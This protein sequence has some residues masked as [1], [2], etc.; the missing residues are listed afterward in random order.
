MKQRYLPIAALI[1][2]HLRLRAAPLSY[3]SIAIH[4]RWPHSGLRSRPMA[5]T[6]SEQFSFAVGWA[7]PSRHSPG[8]SPATFHIN[9]P[10]SQDADSLTTQMLGY[11]Q[12][13]SPASLLPNGAPASSMV[14]SPLQKNHWTATW[15]QSKTHTQNILSPYLGVSLQFDL[16]WN[17]KSLSRQSQYLVSNIYNPNSLNVGTNI[18]SPHAPYCCKKN[19]L[20]LLILEFRH[21]ARA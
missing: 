8:C 12:P 4:G 7:C 15:L 5:K 21:V 17:F 9:E 13:S 20:L 19:Q 1:K 6:P 14:S 18:Q 2:T 3:P 10:R 11:Q 16:V